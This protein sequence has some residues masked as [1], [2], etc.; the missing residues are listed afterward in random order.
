MVPPS[1]DAFYIN[2]VQLTYN[3]PSRWFTDKFVKGLDIYVN[4]NDLL[5]VCSRHKYRETSVG[6]APQNR[7]YNLGVKV[8]F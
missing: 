3:L 1:I 2:Q 5:S 7:S 4:G 8:N 6:G